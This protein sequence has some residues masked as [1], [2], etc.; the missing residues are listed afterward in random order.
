MSAPTCKV[1]RQGQTTGIKAD[2]LVVGDIVQLNVGDIVPAD[3]RLLNGMNF[4]TDEAL[5][6]GESLPVIK[7]PQLTLI[8]KELPLGDRT[9]LAY[10]ASTVSAGRATG[11]VVSTGMRTEVG[12]IADLLRSQ[13]TL[14]E[15]STSISRVFH[16]FLDGLKNILGLIG[17]PLQVKLSKFALL[18]F[19]LAVLL[20]IIVFSAAVWDIS[21]EVLIYGICVAVAVI[22]ESLI[23]VLT[24]TMAVGTKAMA[25]GNVI[26]RKLASLESIGGVTAICSDKTGQSCFTSMCLPA[27]LPFYRHRFAP[28][29]RRAVWR[30]RTNI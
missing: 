16:R 14:R 2:L 30:R 12:K 5:L 21:S 6:T 7:T 18:L 29:G 22:P 25:K 9:N 19:A 28:R 24:I 8:E 17:T 4:A 27:L 15:H 13:Q 1:M 10:S 20:A 26:V 3:L 23:A 11:V